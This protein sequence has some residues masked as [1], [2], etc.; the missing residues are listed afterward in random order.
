[1][2][3]LGFEL[4][5]GGGPLGPRRV[6]TLALTLTLTLTLALALAL[7]LTPHRS[8]P[9]RSTSQSFESSVAP[10]ASPPGLETDWSHTW[11]GVGG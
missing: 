11:L 7:A 3:G 9:A 2:V 8:D 5:R 6:L 10:V 1:V 4:L